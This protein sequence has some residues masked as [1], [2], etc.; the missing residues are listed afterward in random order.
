[1]KL[2]STTEFSKG[3]D[4]IPNFDQDTVLHIRDSFSVEDLDY[5]IGLKGRPAAVVSCYMPYFDLPQDIPFYGSSMF[6]EQEFRLWNNWD[7]NQHTHNNHFCFNF[8]VNKKNINRW[9]VM[10]LVQWLDLKSY[11][12]T[13]SGAARKRDMRLAIPEM[14]FLLHHKDWMTSEFKQHLLAENTMP[15]RWIAH[16]EQY[17][18]FG[19]EFYSIHN[20]GTNRWTWDNGLD[21]VFSDSCVS[22]ITETVEFQPGIILSEKT[23]YSVIGLTLPIWIG[24]YKAAETW[25]AMGFDIFDDIVNHE[26]QHCDTLLERCYRALIDNLALLTD[27]DYAS[28]CRQKVMH[29]LVENRRLFLAN[30]IKEYNDNVMST[31]PSGIQSSGVIGLLHQIYR[32]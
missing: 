5:L 32:Q 9:Y 23:V 10:K 29:R 2:I 6:L 21:R 1:M 31:W 18:E 11:N 26:Y 3:L 28:A 19:D 25:K 16:P 22:L 4:C 15:E 27:L 12:Y 30:K 8:I 13:Y 24:G 14:D 20:Y 17:H 7:I